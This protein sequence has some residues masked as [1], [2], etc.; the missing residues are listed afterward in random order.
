MEKIEGE[1]KEIVWSTSFTKPRKNEGKGIKVTLQNLGGHTGAVATPGFT[2]DPDC[3]SF[4]QSGQG[5]LL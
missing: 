2:G 3:I 5:I 1:K 4:L